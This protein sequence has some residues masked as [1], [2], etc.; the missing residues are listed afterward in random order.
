MICAVP[1]SFVASPVFGP[2]SH[3]WLTLFQSAQA[4]YCLNV[5]SRADYKA[6]SASVQQ[7]HR[8]VRLSLVFHPIC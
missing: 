8:K 7:L 3:W 2:T 1:P 4:L 5:T 6:L